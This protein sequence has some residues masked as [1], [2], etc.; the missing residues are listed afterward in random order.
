MRNKVVFFFFK[1]ILDPQARIVQ[2]TTLWAKWCI[3]KHD[4]ESSSVCL[5]FM[6]EYV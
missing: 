4:H 2:D 6:S 3:N 5:P 1:E